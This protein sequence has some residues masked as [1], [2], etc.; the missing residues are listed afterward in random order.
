MF[1]MRCPG[2]TG[3][4]FTRTH[5]YAIQATNNSAELLR[6]EQLAHQQA[7]RSVAGPAPP[8]S[9]RRKEEDQ[10][11]SQIPSPPTELPQQSPHELEAAAA[12]L[13]NPQLPVS[14]LDTCARLVL[15]LLRSTT[16]V[17]DDEGGSIPLAD[18]VL[19]G[20]CQLDGHLKG[21]LIS[22]ASALG[23]RLSDRQIRALLEYAEHG[24]DGTLEATDSEGMD[25]VD[26]DTDAVEPLAHLALALH[27]NPLPLIRDA[28][29]ARL[30]ALTSLDLAYATVPDFQRFV[31]VLPAGLRSLGLAGVRGGGGQVTWLHGLTAMSRKLT[32]LRVSV[33]SS[34]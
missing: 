29:S 5:A 6:R 23:C 22:T 10:S 16:V 26:W 4:A 34:R 18:A 3:Q 8:R 21:L 9:W 7:A 15:R 14:L 19:A 20:A 28:P 30:L 11:Q 27:P 13:G 2:R 25:G 1:H 33:P 12:F 24:D 32:L 31:A 17:D